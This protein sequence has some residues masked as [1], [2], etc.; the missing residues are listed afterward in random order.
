MSRIGRV[1]GATP[2]LVAITSCGGG[3]PDP[4]VE[5]CVA[6]GVTY[7]KDIGSYPT[8]TSP[9]NTGRRAEDVARERCV[10]MTTAF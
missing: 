9:P 1:L 6:R 8:L 2:L 7:F 10:R 4:A 3:G 5:A